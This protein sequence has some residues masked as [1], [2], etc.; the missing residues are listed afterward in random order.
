MGLMMKAI[1]RRAVLVFV[2][3]FAATARA[4]DP[5]VTAGEIK[6]G[7]IACETGWM[8]D[9]AA[10]TRS[11]AAYFTMVNDHGGVHGRKINF[12]SLDC[13]SDMAHAV[14]LTHKLVD[15]EKVF[16]VFGS[17]G[18]PAALEV[19][20][21]LNDQKIPELFV[22]SPTS[23]LN[24]P[25]HFPYTMGFAPS[26]RIEAAVFAKYILD[27]KPK[28]KIAVL[29]SSD[30]A[31]DDL[32]AGLHDGLG[33]RYAGMVIA[34]ESYAN[35][36]KD[37]ATHVLACKNSGADVFCD[38]SMGKFTTAAVRQAYDLDWHPLQ[39]IPSSSLSVAAFLDP[40]G[41]DKAK[42]IL[43]AAR[44][45]GWNS[46]L[47]LRD[48]EVRDYMA[49]LQK[50]N[51]QA[52]E[53]DQL[54]VL[55]YELGETMTAVLDQCGDDVSREHVMNIAKK[56]DLNIGMLLPGIKVQTT[57][58]DYRPVH[59]LFLMQFNGQKWN[60]IGNVVGD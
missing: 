34:D 1:V 17:V 45:K 32:L 56:L 36:D 10:I 49:W 58:T 37:I 39:F 22:A 16:L 29:H 53:R 50:Y 59:Q 54:N 11:E 33:D 4:A 51:P 52:K 60:R 12:V 9:Y 3:S 31:G 43:T 57:P 6:I 2:F 41:L 18:G 20:P 27:N 40:A 7:N 25:A 13:G 5:G 15:E 23:K 38:F 21:F 48:S 55:G 19:R 44:S 28:G 35:A 24:D 8:S 26:G 30:E 42:E 14:E 46:T 47:A